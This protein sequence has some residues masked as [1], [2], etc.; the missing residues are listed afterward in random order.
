MSRRMMLVL[1]RLYPAVTF[2]LRW[3]QHTDPTGETP[4][5]RGRIKTRGGK[6]LADTQYRRRW[7]S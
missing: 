5:N 1:S 6:V 2:E 7:V 4:E 3:V